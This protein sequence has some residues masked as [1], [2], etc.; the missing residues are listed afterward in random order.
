MIMRRY[1]GVLPVSSAYRRKILVYRRIQA[2][3]ARKHKSCSAPQQNNKRR[4]SLQIQKLEHVHF[5]RARTLLD[6]AIEAIKEFRVPNLVEQC[7]DENC[8]DTV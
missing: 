1:Y 2:R 3:N 4:I 7:T 8:E 5:K 6:R